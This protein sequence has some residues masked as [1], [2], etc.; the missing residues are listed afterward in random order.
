METE[1]WI[2]VFIKYI[3]QYRYTSLMFLVFSGIFAGIFFLYDLET[4][5]V[6][7]AA[8]L[9][10][11]LSAVVI[12]IHFVSYLR[13][14]RERENMLRNIDVMSDNLIEADTLAEQD[15]LEMA[16]R[17]K[18]LLDESIIAAKNDKRE[19]LE[20]YTTWVHQIKTPISVIEMILQSED[21]PE[22]LELS[23][24][25]FRIE[26]YVDMVLNYIRLGGETNDFVFE[27]YEIDKIIKSAV[28]KYAPQFVR[29]RIRLKYEPVS[30]KVITDEKWLLF[31]LEQLLS[32]A[33]KYTEKGEVAVCVTDDKI[34]KVSDTGIGIAKEDIP[35]IF[36]KGFTGYNGRSGKK[37]SGLGLFLCRL[38]A[39]RLCHKLS[40]ESEVGKGTVFKLDLKRYD[41]KVE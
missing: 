39:D 17:L 14:H 28:H 19:S 26:Q 37:S 36:E 11:L 16:L 5:A 29:K 7:Y 33:V 23:A 6:L 38:A 10:A 2:V 27:E 20:Y 32:N 15:Y 12:S 24:E 34:L 3:K 22:H 8:G 21:T 4:E 9:C 25:L 31:I 35:R 40:V 18:V 41:L 30:I 13:K 1:K